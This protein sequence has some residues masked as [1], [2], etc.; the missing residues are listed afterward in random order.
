MGRMELPTAPR[1]EDQGSETL[2]SAKVTHSTQLVLLG[3]LAS[4][5]T[6]RRGDL[7]DF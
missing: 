1:S 3:Y 7:G 4:Q 6:T 5:E 2:I